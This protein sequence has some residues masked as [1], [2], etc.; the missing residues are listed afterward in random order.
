MME[1]VLDILKGRK[2][3]VHADQIA[4]HFAIS[5]N[6]AATIL[7]RLLRDNRVKV[8]AIGKIRYYSAKD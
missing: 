7:R 2:T 8:T 4:G 3:P 5:K 1:R 6:Y